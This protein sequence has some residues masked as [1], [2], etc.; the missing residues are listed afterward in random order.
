MARRIAHLL[1][2]FLAFASSAHGVSP[3]QEDVTRLPPP[4][5][6]RQPAEIAPPPIDSRY[7]L[8][9]NDAAANTIS[10]TNLP[11]EGLQA[12]GPPANAYDRTNNEAVSNSLPQALRWS[13]DPALSET[14]IAQYPGSQYFNQGLDRWFANQY[15]LGG[16]WLGI[17]AVVRSYYLDDQR[18]EWSGMEATFAVEGALTGRYER[19]FDDIGFAVG[20]DFFITQ[21]YDGNMYDDPE[22]RSYFANFEYRPFDISQ[23]YLE[24]QKGRFVCRAGKII[25][26]FGR[27]YYP[28]DTNLQFDAPFIRTECIRRRETGVL[29][30]YL[31]ECITTDVAMVNGCD[32]RDT[33]SSKGVVGRVGYSFE[34][35][36]V[37]ISGKLQDGI[38]SEEQ[39]AYNNHVGMDAACRLGKWTVSGEAIYDEHGGYHEFDPNQI[40]WEHSIYYRE[41]NKGVHS[42]IT[43]VG[44]YVD[45]LYR[46]DKWLLEFNFGQY[47]PE[48]I[49][50]PQHDAVNHRGI[51]R[52][53]YDIVKHLQ[54]YNVL[55]IEN[56][57]PDAQAGR[58]RKP[59]VEMIGLQYLF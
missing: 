18:I 1:C 4:T 55:M 43:G 32:D 21:P 58:D 31:G 57:L 20:S 42:R 9:S 24:V 38:G 45:C 14:P 49:G 34:P 16:G 46:G 51:V 10:P 28:V 59:W 27:F 25:T 7:T 3:Q 15:L 56:G 41:V 52:V 36:T 30:R 6:E 50:I 53:G 12:N 39:K 19:R 33:N 26:P 29:F 17:D 35:F 2:F 22:R 23:L 48:R 13:H 40:F 54:I 44:W 37:G 11:Q 47:Y 8:A 5:S